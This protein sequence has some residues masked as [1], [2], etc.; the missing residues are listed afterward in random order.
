MFITFLSLLILHAC[1][2]AHDSICVWRSENKLQEWETEFRSAGFVADASSCGPVS[3][4][5]DELLQSK[6]SKHVG[7]PDLLYP[8]TS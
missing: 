5:A 3:A 7:G 4:A 6:V 1:V 2:H 8:S